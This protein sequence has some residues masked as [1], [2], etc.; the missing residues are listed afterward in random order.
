VW[1]NFFETH[2][3]Y[4]RAYLARLNYVHQNAVKHGFV[5]IATQYQWC[6]ARWLERT[7]PPAFQKSLQ[8]FRIDKVKVLDDFVPVAP[9]F[10][11]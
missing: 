10:S 11:V 7:G 8:R 9:D 6:S 2:L 1:F 3:T 4:Q 5:A